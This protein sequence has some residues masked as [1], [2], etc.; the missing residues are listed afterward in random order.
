[1]LK[2]KHRLQNKDLGEF[3]M[4]V[5]MDRLN[6]YI[7]AEIK[8]GLVNNPDEL[9]VSMLA[10]ELFRDY[11]KKPNGLGV[12]RRGKIKYR[13]YRGSGCKKINTSTD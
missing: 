2:Y 8:K 4:K 1:M 11:L 12:Q 7:P 10:A 3:L 9:P 13:Y 6:L 5:E